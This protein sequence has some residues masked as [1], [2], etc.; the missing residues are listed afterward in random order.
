[1]S[2]S[3]TPIDAQTAFTGTVAPTGTDILDAK[4]LAQWMDAHVEGFE[5]PVEVLKFAGG[6]SNP[7]YRLNTKSGSYVLRRKPFGVLLPSAHAVDREYKVTAGLYPTGFPVA[8][9]FGLCTDDSVAGSMFYIMDMVET[10]EKKILAA[11]RFGVVI[12]ENGII[13]TAMNQPIIK[14][15][16]EIRQ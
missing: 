16:T 13:G 5:G 15:K 1:M 2:T 12:I 3:P 11:T 8:K 6:Q 14:N 4:A 7:T 10:P 9:P